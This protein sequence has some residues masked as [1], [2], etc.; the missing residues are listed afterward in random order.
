MTTSRD[1]RDRLERLAG[2]PDA[3]IDTSDIP[4]VLDWSGAVRGG[5]YKPLKEAITIRLDADVL[6]WFKE[7]VGGGRGYQSEIN[8]VLR[9][10]I[11]TIAR[12]RD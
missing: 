4:E 1:Q 8:R 2:A 9:Q 6:A 5:L 3:T 7:Q 12:S 11:A 10:H